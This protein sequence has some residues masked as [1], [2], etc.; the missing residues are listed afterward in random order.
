M[1]DPLATTI[2][3]LPGSSSGVPLIVPVVGR[4]DDPFW[5]ISEIRNNRLSRRPVSD[6]LAFGA[7]ICA[8]IDAAASPRHG[9]SRA[10]GGRAA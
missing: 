8:R 3:G 1:H 4:P 7:P 2:S 9:P 5:P 10:V 6:D